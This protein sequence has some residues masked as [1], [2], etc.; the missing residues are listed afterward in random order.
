[1]WTLMQFRNAHLFWAILQPAKLADAVAGFSYKIQLC[2]FMSCI[3]HA[4]FGSRKFC[5]EKSQR[6]FSSTYKMMSEEYMK[7]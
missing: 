5:D 6:Y 7:E 4:R 1:M 3:L 2:P